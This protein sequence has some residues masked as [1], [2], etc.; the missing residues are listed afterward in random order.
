MHVLHLHQVRIDY[1]AL[2]Q[3]MGNGSFYPLSP[4][5]FDP[6]RDSLWPFALEIKHYEL[7]YSKAQT[8]DK[9]S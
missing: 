5:F 9:V 6:A 8:L 3:A 7:S 2:A 4:L 1:P